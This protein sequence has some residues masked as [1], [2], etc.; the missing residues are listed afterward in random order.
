MRNPTWPGRLDRTGCAAVAQ[1]TLAACS[2]A[3]GRRADAL[4]KAGNGDE[5]RDAGPPSRPN[6][7]R[8][9]AER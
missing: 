7:R 6:A 3:T 5:A 1:R 4:L 8:H 9:H 2:G